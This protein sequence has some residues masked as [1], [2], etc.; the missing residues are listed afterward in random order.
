[1]KLSH[2]SAPF[3]ACLALIAT[4]TIAAAQNWPQWRGPNRDAKAADF[5][6][7]ANW[8]AE[9]TKKWQ[10][11]VGDGVATPALVDGKLYV[12]TRQDGREIL[13]CLNA[14]TNEELWQES[15]ETEGASGGAGRFPGP[16]SSPTVEGGKVVTLGLR[17]VLICREADTGKTIWQTD[18]F[19]KSWP[20]FFTS[21]SPIFIGGICI[22][23]LGGE[24]DGGIVAYDLNT[25]DEKWRWMG[26]GPAYGSP[27]LM[28]IEGTK[29]IV[30]PAERKLVAVTATDGK[31]A[32][33]LPY[34]QGRYN[35][36]SPIIDGQTLLVAGPGI[37]MT[38]FKL[39]KDGERIVEEK[40][41]TYRDNSVGFNTPVL[42]DGLLFGL[43]NADQLF[44]MNVENQTTA[45]SAPFAQPAAGEAASAAGEGNSRTERPLATFVQFV[46]PSEPSPSGRGQGEGASDSDRPERA[47]RDGRDGERRRGD[48][49]GRFGRGGRGRGGRGGGRGGYGSIVDAGSVLLALTPAGELV[50]FKPSD[51]AYTELARYKVAAGGTYAYPVAAEN[52]IYIKDQN[53]LT[54]WTVD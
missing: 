53:D 28:D 4:A 20:Q 42:K 10:V 16:R 24:D 36:A 6:A 45:W 18:E 37:G 47:E 44:C 12:F 2:S 41:W 48:G 43:S 34:E 14:E 29:V 46:Q 3:C 19:T 54:L 9:L 15:Y 31:L 5:A 23:Q 1:V 17:G 32:W 8:P 21:S 11:T 22:A 39:K 40:L 52:K 30:T 13:R 38:A 33:E 26:A 49:R 27:A 50:V 51:E 7:P 25:G 35:A